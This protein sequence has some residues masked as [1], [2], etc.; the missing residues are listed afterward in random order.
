[1]SERRVGIITY[2][3]NKKSSNGIADDSGGRWNCQGGRSASNEPTTTSKNLKINKRHHQ[4]LTMKPPKYNQNQAGSYKEGSNG[5]DDG[6][7]E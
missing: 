1:M 3:I 6:F 4:N 2:G 5:A 7:R